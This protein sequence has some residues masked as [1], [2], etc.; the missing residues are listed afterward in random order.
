VRVDSIN[1]ELA[2]ET[3]SSGYLTESQILHSNG[4]IIGR[5]FVSIQYL[6]GGIPDPAQVDYF[7][8]ISS[9]THSIQIPAGSLKRSGIYK[10]CTL[11]TTPTYQP[12][13]MP[14]ARRGSQDDCIRVKFM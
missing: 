14:V 4:N 1:L 8:A 9:S 13:I 12:V 11:T 6:S 2:L 10:I 5:R 3:Q 7:G